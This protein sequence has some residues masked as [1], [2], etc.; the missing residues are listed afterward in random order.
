MNSKEIMPEEAYERAEKFL[1]WNAYKL[2][3]STH[4]Q[5]NWIENTPTNALYLEESNQL[6][7]I[8]D[9]CIGCLLCI[10]SCPRHAIE[11]NK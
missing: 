2:T 8:E 3:F 7:F 10:D 6:E 11:E 1:P 4:I 9:K 5:P